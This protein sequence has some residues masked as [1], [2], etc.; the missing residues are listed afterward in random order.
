MLNSD[1]FPRP[2]SCHRPKVESV[3][4]FISGKVERVNKRRRNSW[5]CS[6]RVDGATMF[7]SHHDTKYSAE[8]K[9]AKMLAVYTDIH[10][11]SN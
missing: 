2:F 5:C 4:P 10:Y 9:C 8:L 3:E 11:V 6:V 7:T 1:L